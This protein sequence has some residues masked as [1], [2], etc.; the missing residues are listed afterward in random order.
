VDCEQSPYADSQKD[1]LK[2]ATYQKNTRNTRSQKEEAQIVTKHN[3]TFAAKADTEIL[4]GHG[5]RFGQ[6]DLTMADQ[7][8]TP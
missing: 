4:G 3:G 5:P 8:Q 1:C 7:I 2:N 6:H